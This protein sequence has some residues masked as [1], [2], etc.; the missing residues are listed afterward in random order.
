MRHILFEIPTPWFTIPIMGYGLMIV[1]GFVAGILLGW[2]RAKRCGENPEHILNLGLLALVGGIVGGRLLYVAMNPGQ[3]FGYGLL[4]DLRAIVNVRS[5]GLVY[6]G[7]LGLATAMALWYITRHRLSAR[8][9]LDIVA[10][11]LMLGLA[12]GRMGCFLNGCC[13]GGRCAFES[14]AAQQAF[15]VTFPFGSP[16]FDQQARELPWKV[17]NS[18]GQPISTCEVR[19]QTFPGRPPQILHVAGELSATAAAEWPAVKVPLAFIKPALPE[20]VERSPWTVVDSAGRPVEY[21]VASV[22]EKREDGTPRREQAASQPAGALVVPV[23]NIAQLSDDGPVVDYSYTSR[24][25]L[26]SP[27]DRRLASAYRSLPVYPVQLYGIFNALFIWYI[28]TMFFGRRGREGEVFALMLILKPLSRI[29]LESVR[30]DT[31]AVAFGLTLSQNLS[32]A[33]LFA[34]VILWLWLWHQ[35]AVAPVPT[36]GEAKPA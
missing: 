19:L 31:D 20:A 34:G 15:T 6:Y 32:L 2:W 10:P 36:S 26:K 16:A 21:L 11:S 35:P 14:P 3:F 22:T 30:R 1:L 29:L 18:D 27:N 28:L 5:G 12:F 25:E 23:G 13:W 8:R 17:V 7:G 24:D 33:A 4:G 9:I